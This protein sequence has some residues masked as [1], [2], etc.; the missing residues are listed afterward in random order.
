MKTKILKLEGRLSAQPRR[1]LP[2]REAGQT[3]IFKNY[4]KPI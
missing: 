2:P 4:K 1:A 3:R